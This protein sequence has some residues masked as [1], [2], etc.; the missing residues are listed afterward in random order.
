MWKRTQFLCFPF[1][2]SRFDASYFEHSTN[3]VNFIFIFYF[4]I[5]LLLF[6]LIIFFKNKNRFTT[7][8]SDG[9]YYM[10][11]QAFNGLEGTRSDVLSFV[12]CSLKQPR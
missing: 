11:V 8:L 2:H 9:V 6:L 4:L 10:A 12:V 5:L 1:R 3:I 7:T